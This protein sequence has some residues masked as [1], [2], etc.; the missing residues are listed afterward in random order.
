MSKTLGFADGGSCSID[1]TIRLSGEPKRPRE[2]N[3]SEQAIVKTEVKNA[4]PFGAWILHHGTLAKID[5]D[6]L[7]AYQR[8]RATAHPL[9]I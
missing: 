9:G 3:H 1:G 7:I 8:I 2:R 5:A 4:G 6:S